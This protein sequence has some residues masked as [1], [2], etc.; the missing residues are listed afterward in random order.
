MTKAEKLGVAR[1]LEDAIDTLVRVASGA[2]G[3]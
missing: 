1:T 3:G 2:R